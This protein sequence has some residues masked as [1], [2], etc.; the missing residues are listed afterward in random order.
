MEEMLPFS[1]KALYMDNGSEFINGNMTNRFS[2]TRN[3]IS[4]EDYINLFRSRPY[5]KNDQCFVE[6][7][8]YT[9][10]RE[11]FGYDRHS[12]HLQTNLMNNIYSKEWF[13]LANFFYPQIRLKSKER[14]GSKIKKAFH[15]ARTPIEILGNYL[16]EEVMVG[17][18]RIVE[19]S[20]PFGLR[21]SLKRK[22]RNFQGYKGKK[23]E[24]LGKYD[25]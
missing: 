9:H 22:L 5:K 14:I 6:Q 4:R 13:F 15:P 1:I 23:G 21:R 24:R 12:G 10:V 25:L 16:T 3:K 20:D 2:K 18:Y 11:L 19:N 8:N 17:L 7:K